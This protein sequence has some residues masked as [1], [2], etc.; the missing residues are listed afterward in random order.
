MAIDYFSR[1][2]YAKLIKSKEA[3]K[4]LNFIKEIHK[5]IKI[6]KLLPDHERKFNNNT[7]ERWAKSESIKHEKN[8]AL[9]SLSQWKDRKSKQGSQNNTKKGERKAKRELLKFAR[10]QAWKYRNVF[11]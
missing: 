3:Q 1:K 8:Q 11:E 6:A 2:F 7:F 4:C 9:I 10:Y 5:Y